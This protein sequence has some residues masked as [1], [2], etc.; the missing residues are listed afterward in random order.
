MEREHNLKKRARRREASPVA[1]G[2][3]RLCPSP[4]RRFSISPRRCCL[5][6]QPVSPAPL[7]LASGRAGGRAGNRPQGGRGR[8]GR[9][10]GG[11]GE[12]LA[13]RRPCLHLSIRLRYVTCW[14]CYIDSR[15]GPNPMAANNITIQRIHY[16]SCVH[17][18]NGSAILTYL[19]PVGASSVT[20]GEHPPSTLSAR[21]GLLTPG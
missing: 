12:R 7:A 16:A 9:G 3:G 20:V 18:A 10:R 1:E 8:G 13:P 4:A 15:R 6:P 11:G 21:V 2:P 14:L 19:A 17:N 5:P